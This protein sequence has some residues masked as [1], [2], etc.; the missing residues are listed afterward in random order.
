MPLMVWRWKTIIMKM[1]FYLWFNSIKAKI[2]TF[3]YIY[4]HSINHINNT[5]TLFFVQDLTCGLFFLGSQ[6]RK[7]EIFKDHMEC[8]SF[9]RLKH[10]Y[11]TNTP[12]P[13]NWLTTNTPFSLISF[14]NSVWCSN[15]MS[16]SQP[17]TKTFDPSRDHTS[18]W[19]G[20]KWN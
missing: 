9:G 16:P 19:K 18:R 14:T 10:I 12:H 7:Y 15:S 4:Q 5:T 2:M 3:Q 17:T 1:V 8:L 20:R 13:P 6:W 11:P